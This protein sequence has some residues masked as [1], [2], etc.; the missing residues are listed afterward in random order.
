MEKLSVGNVGCEENILRFNICR[1]TRCLEFEFRFIQIHFK[2]QRPYY[3]T[4]AHNRNGNVREFAKSLKKSRN[5]FEPMT[6]KIQDENDES[7][8]DDK[9]ILRRWTDFMMLILLIRPQLVQQ[10]TEAYQCAEPDI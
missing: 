2:S 9:S 1:Q 7:L 3:L 4:E 8:I 5:G 10:S 6:S